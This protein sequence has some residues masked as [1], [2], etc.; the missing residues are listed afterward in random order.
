[1]A[2]VVVDEGEFVIMEFAAPLD[3]LVD[4]VGA[5]RYCT[6]GGVSVVRAD[7]AVLSVELADVFGQIP[8]VCVP[9]AVLLDSQRAGGYR[10]GGIP[11]DEPEC[12]M[13]TAGEVTAGKTDDGCKAGWTNTQCLP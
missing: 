10:L 3:G 4:A 5:F 11:G 9:C 13:V 8:A 1:M 7:V 6:I 2:V 12:R